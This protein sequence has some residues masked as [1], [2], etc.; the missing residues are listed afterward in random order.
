MRIVLIFTVLAASILS[1]NVAMAQAQQ[2]PAPMKLYTGSFGGGLALTS[3]N[4]DTKNYNLTFSLTRDPKT[5]NVFK[6]EALYLRATQSDVLN[7]ERAAAK[8]RD[9]YS[10]T[11]KVFLFAEFGY[12]RD[13]FKDIRY[14]LSPG[15]GIGYKF[16]DTDA[17]KLAI[18]GGAGGLFEKNSGVPVKKSGSVNAGQT[19]S[20]KLSADTTFTE[21]VA[22]LWK[23]DDFNDSLTNFRAGLTTTLYKNLELK[24]EFLDTYKS[25]PPLPTIKKNDTAFI[26]TFLLKY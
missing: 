24:V 16:V 11:K 10:L 6:A 1:C 2:T 9:E 17:T 8:V 13:P 18:S 3:G 14:L 15:G 4:T 23:M 7:L 19:L 25:R 22:T 21:S 12:L 26:M 5:R 20:Q